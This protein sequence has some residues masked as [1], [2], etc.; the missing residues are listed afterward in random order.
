MFD[1]V[2]FLIGTGE[3]G[4]EKTEAGEEDEGKRVVGEGELVE[5]GGEVIIESSKGG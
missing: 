3:R 1:Q 2:D 5:T 4:E